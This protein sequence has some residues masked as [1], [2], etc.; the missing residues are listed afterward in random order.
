MP[1]ILS[2]A[3]PNDRAALSSITLRSGG[4]TFPSS[5]EDQKSILRISQ[6]IAGEMQK[7]YTLSFNPSGQSDGKWHTLRVGLRNVA[8]SKNFVLT[9][10]SGYQATPSNKTGLE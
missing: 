10:R 3:S 2:D 9:Y 4:A 7:Q 8:G 6:Q 5:F 1:R